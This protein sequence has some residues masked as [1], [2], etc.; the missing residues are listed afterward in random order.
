MHKFRKKEIFPLEFQWILQ[1]ITETL[2][3]SYWFFVWLIYQFWDL[4]FSDIYF[5]GKREGTSA[6]IFFPQCAYAIF[7]PTEDIQRDLNRCVILEITFLKILS[8]EELLHI[9]YLK[10]LL[11]SYISKYNPEVYRAFPTS[12]KSKRAFPSPRSL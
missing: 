3:L 4:I 5:I 1:F 6:N 12:G 10:V 9:S 11:I 2:V 8:M 7:S